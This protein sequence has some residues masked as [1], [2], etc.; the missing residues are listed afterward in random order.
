MSTFR[1]VLFDQS[2]GTEYVRSVKAEDRVAAILKARDEIF[3]FICEMEAIT[4]PHLQAQVRE[5]LV[6]RDASAS[7]ER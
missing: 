1:V 4:D 2:T 5:D 3:T 7:Q 6:S